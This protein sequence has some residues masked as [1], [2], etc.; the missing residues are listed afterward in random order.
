MNEEMKED[1]CE[2]CDYFKYES[3]VNAYICTS[4]T[5]IHRNEEE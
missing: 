2:G 1:K 4:I 5:C 3:D